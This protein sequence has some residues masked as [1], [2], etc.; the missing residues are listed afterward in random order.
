MGDPERRDRVRLHVPLHGRPSSIRAGS[1]P[2]RR[3]PVGDEHSGTSWSPGRGRRLNEIFGACSSV[4]STAIPAIRSPRGGEYYSFFEPEYAWID[5]SSSRRRSPG[6]YGHGAS[7]PPAMGRG[8]PCSSATARRCACS[9]SPSSPAAG[10]T[11]ECADGT[12]WI[13]ERSPHE[14]ISFSVTG[15]TRSSGSRRTRRTRTGASGTRRPRSS[16]STT[17]TRSSARAAGPCSSRRARTGSR[18]RSTCSTGSSSRAVPTSTPALYGAEAHPETDEP[19][20]AA[21][22]ELALLEAALEHDVPMLADAAAS[23]S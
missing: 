21:T 4:S 7:T 3:S 15:T 8:A 6:R 2:R 10:A 20:R 18:R 23:S 9:G 1:S 19:R 12:L 16:R 14:A 5:T 11:L 13:V 22:G 17:W